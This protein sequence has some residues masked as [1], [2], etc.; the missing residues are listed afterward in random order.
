[1]VISSYNED[2]DYSFGQKSAKI[3]H[4]SL[5]RCIFVRFLKI[6]VFYPALYLF[7]GTFHHTELLLHSLT[8]KRRTMPRQ[9]RKLSGT[10]IRHVILCRHS[11]AG[12]TDRCLFRSNTIIVANE[13]ITRTVPMIYW[14][15]GAAWVLCKQSGIAERCEREGEAVAYRKGIAFEAK[16]QRH[17]L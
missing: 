5:F 1:M 6:F 9:A 8:R 11:P 3:K 4:Q 13:M 7:L 15:S 10:G 17:F 14:P 2:S 12:K 16:K